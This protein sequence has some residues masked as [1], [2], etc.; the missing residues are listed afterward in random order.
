MIVTAARG[1]L[2]NEPSLITELAGKKQGRFVKTPLM[3]VL[4]FHC[5]GTHSDHNAKN[6]MKILS[7]QAELKA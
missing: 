6:H 2:H 4:T 3:L 5:C 7:C 1:L